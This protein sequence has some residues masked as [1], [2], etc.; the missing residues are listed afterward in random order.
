MPRPNNRSQTS[1]ARPHRMGRSL[2]AVENQFEQ[3][4]KLDFQGVSKGPPKPRE[5][6]DFL[7]RKKI[8]ETED[9]DDLKW[10]E[11]AHAFTVAHSAGAGILNDLHEILIEAQEAGQSYD[12]TKREIKQLMTKK[13]WYGRAD[14][15]PENKDPKE[16][17]KAKQYINWRIGII[18]Q[19][20]QLTAYSAGQTRKLWSVQHIY[21]YWQYKQ[22]Q[23]KNKR[24]AH[25]SYHNMVLKADDPAWDAITP[26]NGWRC[27]C[28]RS[29]LTPEQA[30]AEWQNGAANSLPPDGKIDP[31]WAY[32]PAKEA[33]APNWKNYHGLRKAG[34]LREVMQNYRDDIARVQMSRGEWRKYSRSV[35]EDKLGTTEIPLHMGTLEQ[36]VVD[37]LGFDPKLMAS[38]KAIRHAARGRTG[39]RRKKPKGNNRDLTLD[40]IADMPQKLADPEQIFW[41]KQNRSWLFVYKLN[42]E[43][44]A[45]VVFRQNNGRPLQLVS[46]TKVPLANSNENY[47]VPVYAKK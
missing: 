7:K 47:G 44:E 34:I 4:R 17:K 5:A 42:Q 35:V 12:K 32:N 40:E 29:P 9:W 25:S 1:V 46:F 39:S 27:A 19:Q 24:E 2:S 6:I 23:R 10:G 20:N 37:K 33:L 26:P 21:P 31:T 11:H 43:K 16:R 15:D 22:R 8:V 41:D 3:P 30:Q 28:Y 13:G 18:Y 45:R 14:I 38:D 36:K